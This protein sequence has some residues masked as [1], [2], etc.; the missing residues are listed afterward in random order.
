MKEYRICV[1]TKIHEAEVT[2][3][4]IDDPETTLDG[5]SIVFKKPMTFQSGDVLRLTFTFRKPD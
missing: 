2:S 4:L 3:I 1:L 5:M